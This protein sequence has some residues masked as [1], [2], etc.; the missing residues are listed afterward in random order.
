MNRIKEEEKSM[1]VFTFKFG[2][3]SIDLIEY[4]IV[5][6]INKPLKSLLINYL[7]QTKIPNFLLMKRVL[8]SNT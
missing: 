1:K 7:D 4:Q 5:M 2:I 3:V 6:M 8:T